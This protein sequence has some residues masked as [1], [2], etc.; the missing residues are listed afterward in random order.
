MGVAILN[1]EYRQS[2][3]V[4]K[5]QN[6]SRVGK[7]Y[8]IQKTVS[9]LDPRQRHLNLHNYKQERTL[10]IFEA[11]FLSPKT[12]QPTAF[13]LYSEPILSSPGP[14]PCLWTDSSRN[15]V[16]WSAQW[17]TVCKLAEDR[18]RCLIWKGGCLGFAKPQRTLNKDYLKQK[19]HRQQD[20]PEYLKC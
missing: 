6:V 8:A 17:N 14:S 5:Q 16:N 20:R 19:L 3:F 10:A 9:P 2:R 7:Q 18:L 11:Y 4:L 1:T 12:F 13:S 15:F